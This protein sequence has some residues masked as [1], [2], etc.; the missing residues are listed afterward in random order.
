[1]NLYKAQKQVKA[2]PKG[3]T[4]KL[5]RG[6]LTSGFWRIV[7]EQGLPTGKSNERRYE[8]ILRGIA[9]LGQGDLNYGRALFEANY[10]QLRAERL[11]ETEDRFDEARKTIFFLDSQSGALSAEPDWSELNR[12]LKGTDGSRR[13]IAR[14]Y[15][16]AKHNADQ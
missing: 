5:R 10:S 12:F 15:F 14:S 3:E 16:L 11:L 2:L 9:L 8:L 1:M 13:A 4:A 6:R 7:A